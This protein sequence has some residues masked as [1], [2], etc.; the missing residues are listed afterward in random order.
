M[1]EAT[2]LDGTLWTLYENGSL[3]E[4]RTN[5]EKHFVP[6]GA[7]FTDIRFASLFCSG[8]F[9]FMRVK[10]DNSLVD[11]YCYYSPE[12]QA[13]TP[14]DDSDWHEAWMMFQRESGT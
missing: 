13:F 1:W 6:G 3:L 2:S 5:G 4:W 8:G 14:M 7:I 12:S 9:V 11:K 10:L